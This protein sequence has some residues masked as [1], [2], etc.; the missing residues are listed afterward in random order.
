MSGRLHA[1]QPAVDAALVERLIASQHPLWAGLPIERLASDGTTNAI[2]RLGSAA[3][4]RLP[5]V[6]YGEHAIDVEGRWLP[7]L[8]A[9]LPLAIP[10]QLATGEPDTGYPFRWSVHRWI[11]G[12]PVSRGSA[13]DLVAFAQSLATWIAALHRIDAT[14]GPDAVSNDLRGAPLALR[15]AETRR[16]LSALSDEIDVDAALAVWEEALRAD[17]WG[18]P[19]VWCHGDLLP[20]NLLVRDGRLAAVIDFAGL[21]VG[22]PACDLMI[23]WSLFSGESRAAF[24]EALRDGIRLDEATWARGRGHAL[25][26][27]AIYIPYYRHTNPRGTAAV[28][29]QLEAVLGQGS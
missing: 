9:Q 16:G 24:Q 1:D 17:R 2:F 7:R 5:L 8:A 20:G 13:A 29:R 22:D 6:R 18:R 15:D 23:A 4:A 14:G 19:P 27:A 12:E 26:H 21:G 3:S 11:E 10:A 28:R 25:Y